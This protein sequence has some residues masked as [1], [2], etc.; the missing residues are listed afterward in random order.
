MFLSASE[1]NCVDLASLFCPIWEPKSM[2]TAFRKH[3]KSSFRGF[4]FFSPIQGLT[5]Q[6]FSSF[7]A[8][9][10]TPK[11]TKR[12]EKALPKPVKKAVGPKTTFFRR[13]SGFSV[14]L[15]SIFF[16][17]GAQTGFPER[18]FEEVFF[19]SGFDVFF[20]NLF[21]NK[22][23][24]QE[25]TNS[26]KSTFYLGKTMI[27]K[28]R[29]FEK[30]TRCITNTHPKQLWFFVGFWLKIEQNMLKTTGRTRNR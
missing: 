9:F 16:D 21:G 4:C 27:F 6:V 11:S 2:K 19:W 14:A 20:Y 23:L 7:L 25:I 29:R 24:K 10:W 13:F 3:L 5:D 15:A 22:K 17:V 26:W 12:R 1:R 18:L 28:V 30:Q 8:P